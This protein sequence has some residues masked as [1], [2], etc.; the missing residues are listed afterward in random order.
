MRGGRPDKAVA[1]GAAAPA[2]DAAAPDTPTAPASA[3]SAETS[4]S[5]ASCAGTAGAATAPAGRPP[6][7][8]VAWDDAF[9]FYYAENL[10]LLR[11]AGAQLV[12][13]SPLE[14]AELPVC[15]GLYL[16]GGYPELHVAG[17]SANVPLR[18]H[19]SA[20]LATGLP[21]YAECGGLLYLS[22]SLKDLDGRTWPLIGAVPGQAAMHDG[23]QGMGYREAVLAVDS[24]LGPVGTVVRGHEFH[25]SSWV[26]DAEHPAYLVDG[27]PEGYA[28]G[29]LFA[30]YIH[31]HFAGYPAL[32]EHWLERCRVRAGV[33]SSGGPAA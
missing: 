28:A 3:P 1:S 7:I 33:S 6:R 30:S 31:V 15:D 10:D 20:V 5:A 27:A 26:T 32:L 22:E 2:A 4:S 11:A 24:L 17:L 18:R 23:L 9:A 19:L 14:A 21:V 12:P 13:F 25:Y 16:G 8:A 29:D